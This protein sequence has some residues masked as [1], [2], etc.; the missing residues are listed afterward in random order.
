MYK[1][2]RKQAN[3]RATKGLEIK[4]PQWGSGRQL[5]KAEQGEEQAE[6]RESQRRNVSPRGGNSVSLSPTTRPTRLRY[7]ER[8]R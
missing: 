1:S 5:E 8:E 4:P 6:V 3:S 2:F 7:L